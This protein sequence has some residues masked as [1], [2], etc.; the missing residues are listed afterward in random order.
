M[1][2]LK[3]AFLIGL[4]ATVMSAEKL[5]AAIRELVDD[6]V[7]RGD[8]RPE[9]ARQL[10]EDLKQR[11][12]EGKA[13]FERGV[14]QVLAGEAHSGRRAFVDEADA[15]PDVSDDQSPA[16]KAPRRTN[17]PGQ[18]GPPRK[19]ARKSGPGAAKSAPAKKKAGQAKKSAGPGNRTVLNAKPAAS[20]S[21]RRSADGP[22]GG[23]GKGPAKS[24]AKY[25]KGPKATKTGS[26]PSFGRSGGGKKAKPR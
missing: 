13:H 4:G 24:T 14:Q 8:V 10:A 11:F 19:G 20:S 26:S 9:E 22:K 25:T 15:E 21:T 23:A 16:R 1:E 18:S 2:A 3:R 12:L 5:R 6:M 7:A 17:R